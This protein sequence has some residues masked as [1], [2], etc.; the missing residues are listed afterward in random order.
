MNDWLVGHLLDGYAGNNVAVFDF[1]TVLTSNGG[2]PAVNDLGATTGNHHRWRNGQIEHVRGLAN[3]FSSYPSGDSHPSAAGGQKASGEFPALLNIAYHCW[4]GTG[5]CP[6]STTC[7]VTC[8]ATVPG[9]APPATSVSFA[10]SATPSA[11]CTGG[12]TYNWDFGDGSVHSSQ[13]NPSHTY[14]QPGTYTWAFEASSGG[15]TC[16]KGGTIVISTASNCTLT[17]SAET[18]WDGTDLS[19]LFNS[20]ITTTGCTGTPTYDWDFGDGSSHSSEEWPLHYYPAPGTYTWGF[21]VHQDGTTCTQTGTVHI[22]APPVVTGVQ[23]MGNPFRIKITGSNFQEGVSV[24][25]GPDTSPWS[26]TV[27]KGDTQ[28]LLKGGSGLK[29]RFPQGQAVM[30]FVHNTDGGLAQTSYTRP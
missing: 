13:Q 22:A 29:S 1:Y 8:S 6:R 15:V 26:S 27:R 5:G 16:T 4:K 23:K 20:Y 30:I 11:G 2:S 3:D 19:V 18:Y 10:G 14:A 17:C 21:A 28:I 7:A 12:V 9:W 24:S 25:I